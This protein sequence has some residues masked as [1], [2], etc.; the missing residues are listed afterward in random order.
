MASNKVLKQLEEVQRGCSARLL[1]PH[2]IDSII[3][4]AEHEAKK[5]PPDLRHLLRLEYQPW[6]VA[7]AYS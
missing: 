4:I 3:T 7:K 6:S 1:K 2:D 5:V